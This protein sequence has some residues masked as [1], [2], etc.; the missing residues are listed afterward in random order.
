[1]ARCQQNLFHTEELWSCNSLF[2][3]LKYQKII[4]VYRGF[5]KGTSGLSLNTGCRRNSPDERAT[6]AVWIFGWR[7]LGKLQRALL[8][9]HSYNLSILNAIFELHHL[10]FQSEAQFSSYSAG[11]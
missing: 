8:K 4:Y 2:N 3:D 1:M 7:S 11:I 10:K 9:S 5:S 6:I